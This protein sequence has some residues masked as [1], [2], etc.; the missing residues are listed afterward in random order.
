MKNSEV[1]QAVKLF[2]DSYRI[3]QVEGDE[4]K[5]LYDIECNLFEL[6]ATFN[7]VEFAT[8]QSR[9]ARFDNMCKGL[10][11]SQAAEPVEVYYSGYATWCERDSDNG[12][13]Y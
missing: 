7:D 8:Y 1:N 6:L 9:V 11:N 4:F 13:D 2:K 3:D 5:R 10:Q 12:S